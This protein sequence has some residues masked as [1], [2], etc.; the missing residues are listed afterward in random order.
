MLSFQK[1][2]DNSGKTMRNQVLRGSFT[3]NPLTAALVTNARST[4]GSQHK[5]PN[6]AFKLP[7]RAVFQ[8]TVC[9]SFRPTRFLCDFTVDI[10]RGFVRKKAPPEERSPIASHLAASQSTLAAAKS[11]LSN[12]HRSSTK[13][14]PSA[15]GS[16]GKR[17][18]TSD[19]RNTRV[20]YIMSLVQPE[21]CE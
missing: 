21:S 13:T 3:P 19:M 8:K 9:T 1:Y 16:T 2:K 5:T 4:R 7:R 6:N 11:T 18:K 15:F 17:S 10:C 20:L 12:Q 14:K